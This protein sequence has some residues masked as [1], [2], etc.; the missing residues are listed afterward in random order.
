MES[1]P[2]TDVGGGSTWQREDGFEKRVVER[3]M[4]GFEM[5]EGMPWDK[6][7]PVLERK[8]WEEDYLVLGEKPWDMK[9]PVL[10]KSEE[11]QFGLGTGFEIK[12]KGGWAVV[13][14][15]SD[16]WD[17]TSGSDEESVFEEEEAGFWED[18][19]EGKKREEVD[20][21]ERWEWEWSHE[22]DRYLVLNANQHED[23]LTVGQCVG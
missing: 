20:R 3:E 15:R 18:D 2:A 9:Y 1:S 13:S 10:Q 14:V 8:L 7:Y 22:G 21:L 12:R 4:M 11:E 17:E 6:D 19:D 23:I 5:G 16:P